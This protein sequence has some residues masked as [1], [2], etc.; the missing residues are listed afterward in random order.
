MLQSFTFMTQLLSKIEK[1][2]DIYIAY[3]LYNGNKTHRYYEYM[4]NKYGKNYEGL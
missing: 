2:F 1:W 3:F 4:R